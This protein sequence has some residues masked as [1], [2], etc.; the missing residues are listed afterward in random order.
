MASGLVGDRGLTDA[1][2]TASER[3]GET[4]THIDCVSGC[5]PAKEFGHL[6]G[7]GRRSTAR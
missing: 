3:E 2:A 4:V 5:P 7:G 6:V 1:R